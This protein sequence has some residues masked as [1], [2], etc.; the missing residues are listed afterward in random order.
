MFPHPGKP[1]H[2]RGD[3]L[4]Q[5]GSFRGLEESAAVSLQQAEQREHSAKAVLRGKFIAIQAFL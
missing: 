4:G 5:K 2:W 1:L 3:Q